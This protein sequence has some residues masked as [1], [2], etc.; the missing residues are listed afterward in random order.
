MSSDGF[1]YIFAVIG[2]VVTAVTA[3][4]GIAV[5]VTMARLTY[6]RLMSVVPALFAPV[7]VVGKQKL[8]MSQEPIPAFA[9][10]TQASVSPNGG[11]KG[12]SAPSV[13]GLEVAASK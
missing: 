10:K 2:I 6:G 5:T 1:L 13:K 9:E 3:A 4:L 8:D 7:G 11:R 12:P